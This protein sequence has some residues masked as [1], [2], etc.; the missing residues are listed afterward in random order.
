MRQSSL[1]SS[2]PP[3]SASYSVSG[4]SQSPPNGSPTHTLNLTSPNCSPYSHPG[5]HSPYSEPTLT[6]TSYNVPSMAAQVPPP[7]LE[8]SMYLPMDIGTMGNNTAAYMPYSTTA[9]KQEYSM[10]DYGSDPTYYGSPAIPGNYP[11]SDSTSLKT[12]NISQVKARY[13]KVAV[14]GSHTKHHHL[15]LHE[16]STVQDITHWL[17]GSVH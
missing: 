6:P 2:S 9:I 7:Y 15:P 5:G 17:Q 13:T 14:A 10:M 3:Q 11:P 12:S 16:N 1:E 4:Y 8:T